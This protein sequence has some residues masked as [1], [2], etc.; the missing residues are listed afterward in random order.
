MSLTSIAGGLVGNGAIIAFGDYADGIS[1]SA[2]NINLVGINSFAYSM[3]R[4]GTITSISAYFSTLGTLSLTG[5]TVTITAQVYTSPGPSPSDIFSP[6]AGAIVTLNPP[7]TGILGI[8]VPSWGI[9]NGLSI[10]VT[11]QSRVL[12]F[13]SI[14]ATGDSL[15]NTVTGFASA[16]I[17]ID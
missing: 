17:N 8:G 4:D 3:P 5:T 13:F 7:L 6:V 16:G 12:V 2:G 14:T 1:L 10:S 9:T 15:I 11:N